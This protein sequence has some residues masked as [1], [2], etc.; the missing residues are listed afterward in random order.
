M[1][2]PVR[3]SLNS[4]ILDHYFLQILYSFCRMRLG[5]GFLRLDENLMTV[6]TKNVYNRPRERGESID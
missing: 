3:S 1:S 5:A 2:D 6:W 4:F